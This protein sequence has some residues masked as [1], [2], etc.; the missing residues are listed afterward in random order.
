MLAQVDVELEI[1]SHRELCLL[2]FHILRPTTDTEEVEC[3]MIQAAFS[4][5]KCLESRGWVGRG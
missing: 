2:C 5:H 1:K 4:H 3:G